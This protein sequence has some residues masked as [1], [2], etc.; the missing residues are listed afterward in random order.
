[1]HKIVLCLTLGLVSL[2]PHYVQA[3]HEQSDT[4]QKVIKL[5][6]YPRCPYCRKVITFLEQNKWHDKVLLLDANQPEHY[7]ALLKIS[8]SEVCPY[9][10]DEIHNVSMP[11]SA[12]I[13]EY[14]TKIFKNS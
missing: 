13:I 1:M 2:L 7:L 5:Y 6:V 8:G 9:L 10:V 12:K 11:E 14:F 4:T 3:A